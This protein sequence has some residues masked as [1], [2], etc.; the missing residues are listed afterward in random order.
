MGKNKKDKQKTHIVDI[1]GLA[2][3]LLCSASMILKTWKQYPHFYIGHG[4]TAK[5]ARFDVNDVID[6]LKKRDY[7]VSG[8]KKENMDRH[9]S[10]KRFAQESKKGIQDKDSGK[11]VGKGNI[12]KLTEPTRDKF[13]LLRG[14][15]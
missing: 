1:K 14:I 3:V 7:A 12:I 13:N 6:Y 10:K 15:K 8:Q 5:G 11:G 2:Q 9:N 4:C